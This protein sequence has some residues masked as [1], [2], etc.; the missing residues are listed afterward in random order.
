[1]VAAAGVVMFIIVVMLAR[2]KDFAWPTFFLV[3][4]WSLVAYLVLTGM[5][6]SIFVLDGHA[7]RD[8]ATPDL[9]A[10]RTPDLDAGRFRRRVPVLLGFSVARYQ[11]APEAPSG[12]QSSAG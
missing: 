3:G 2:L 5:L 12:R 6:E 9:D 1:L 4:K 7:G 10:G 11:P 8:A